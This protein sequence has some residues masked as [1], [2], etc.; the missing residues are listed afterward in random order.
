[1]NIPFLIAVIVA[2]I[3]FIIFYFIPKQKENGEFLKPEIKPYYNDISYILSPYSSCEW[4]KR[5][6]RLA[7]SELTSIFN[8]YTS[9]CEQ[10]PNREADIYSHI[11]E[12]RNNRTY[13]YHFSLTFVYWGTKNAH[14][15]VPDH[16]QELGRTEL[17]KSL[18][19]KMYADIDNIPQELFDY[20]EINPSTIKYEATH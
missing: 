14:T 13:K 15:A 20:F 6:N 3:L 5:I 17:Q 19:R 12:N 9:L 1:M 7:I 10:N 16:T 2:G 18:I 4:A 11:I 8:A